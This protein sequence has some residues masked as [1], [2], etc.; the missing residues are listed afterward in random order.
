MKIYRHQTDALR[1]ILLMWT[2][3]YR[4]AIV[5]EA[6]DEKLDSIA[7]KFSEVYGTELPGW[8]RYE[9]KRKK[10]PNGWACSMP[11]ASH[12]GQNI[13]VLMAA[14]ETLEHLDPASPWRREKWQPAEKLEIGDYRITPND[15]RD[16][17]DHADTIKLTTRT[18]N[19][20]ENYWRALASQGQF[21]KIA[22]EAW[23]AT[24]FYALFGGVRRQLRRLIRGY[25]KLYQA[26]LKK[27]WPGPN[28]EA[29]PSVGSF[30]SA[31]E[32]KAGKKG[33]EGSRA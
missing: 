28:P 29:L 27:P 24:Q 20:L 19:G 33:N 11:K 10:L 16:R 15:K 30:R 6:R 9:R 1:A 5:F 32:D 25:Q 3:G 14:F 31:S 17:R 13:V 12:P 26:R 21:D 8:K 4:H 7:L 23:R 18:I 22:D 2:Q